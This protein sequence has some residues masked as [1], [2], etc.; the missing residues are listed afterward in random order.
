[1]RNRSIDA[2]VLYL[3]GEPRIRERVDG[4][5]ITFIYLTFVPLKLNQFLPSDLLSIN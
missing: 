5:E 3:P 4:M 1:M 2:R